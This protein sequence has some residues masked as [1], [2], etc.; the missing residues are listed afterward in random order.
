MTQNQLAYNNSSKLMS[1]E[2]IPNE[3]KPKSAMK[4]SQDSNRITKNQPRITVDNNDDQVKVRIQ[5]DSTEKIHKTAS[6]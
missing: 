4:R 2:K 3:P 1:S 5:L 6:K